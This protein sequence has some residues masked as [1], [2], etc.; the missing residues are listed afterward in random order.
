MKIKSPLL[1]SVILQSLFFLIFLNLKTNAADY[2]WD[3]SISSGY[4]AGNGTWSTNTAN[5]TVNGTTLTYWPAT[6]GN[7]ATFSGSTG[8]YAIILS[9][10]LNVDSISILTN[11]YTLSSGTI[12]LQNSAPFLLQTVLPRLSIRP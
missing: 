2:I 6:T 5:W 4:Q 11:E 12:N 7:T 3:T 1:L 10:T 9:G 8:T